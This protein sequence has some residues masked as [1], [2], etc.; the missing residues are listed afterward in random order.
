MWSIEFVLAWKVYIINRETLNK[1][2]AWLCLIYQD[3]AIP[4]TT[5]TRYIDGSE[6]DCSYSSALAMELLQSCTEPSIYSLYLLYGSVLYRD[7]WSLMTDEL[8][9]HDIIKILHTEWLLYI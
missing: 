3:S 2:V 9:S 5:L 7:L 1:E 8:I 6:Q 4:I